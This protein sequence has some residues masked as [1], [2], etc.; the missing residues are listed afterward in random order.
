[1]K[2]SDIKPLDIEKLYLQMTKNHA[3]TF[4]QLSNTRTVLNGVFLHAVRLEV[5][6]HSI[7]NDIDYRQFKHRCKPDTSRKEPYTDEERS[8]IIAYLKEKTDIF[9]LAISFAFR[10]CMRIGELR[11]I[12]KSDIIGDTLKIERSARRNQS[13]NDDFTFS[14]IVYTIDERIKGNV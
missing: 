9:S 6:P 5:V 10:H 4:K 11:V 1:M 12:K 2:V 7:T 8:K 14:P 3:V 13:L